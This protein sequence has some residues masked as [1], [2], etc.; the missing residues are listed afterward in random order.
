[1]VG[2][3]RV[4]L[5]KISVY[6]P[7]VGHSASLTD[8]PVV[9][10][11]KRLVLA[12]FVADLEVAAVLEDTGCRILDFDFGGGS[13]KAFSNRPGRNRCVRSFPPNLTDEDLNLVLCRLDSNKLFSKLTVVHARRSFTKRISGRLLVA[14]VSAAV[15]LD[16]VKRIV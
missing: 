12:T 2:R 15:A 6:D 9:H 5:P 8:P 16:V 10:P 1:M 3:A 7:V 4:T 11:T 13:G 14:D